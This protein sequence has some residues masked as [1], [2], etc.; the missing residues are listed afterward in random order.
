[1]PVWLVWKTLRLGLKHLAFAQLDN[2]FITYCLHCLLIC[3]IKT[4]KK[5]HEYFLSRSQICVF[6]SILLNPILSFNPRFVLRLLA[7]YVLKVTALFCASQSRIFYEYLKPV[8][9]E[10]LVRHYWFGSK[11]KNLKTI[12]CSITNAY[13][14][15]YGG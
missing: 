4:L 15:C 9:D 5:A 13:S 1:M 8:N 10:N 11:R 7:S 6:L 2:R 12:A 3:V 14:R